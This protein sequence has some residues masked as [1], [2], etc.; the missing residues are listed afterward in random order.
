MVMFLQATTNIIT[1][2]TPLNLIQVQRELNKAH[3]ANGASS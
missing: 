3:K 1:N 2:I